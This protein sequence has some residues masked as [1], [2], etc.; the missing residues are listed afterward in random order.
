MQILSALKNTSYA[1][2]PI[3]QKGLSYIRHRML[4]GYV[5]SLWDGTEPASS[6]NYGVPCLLEPD[7]DITAL[8]WLLVGEQFGR[9]AVHEMQTLYTRFQL[10][11]G[12]F[13]SYF[14]GLRF[15]K[16]AC[17]VDYNNAPSL[18]VNLK[19]LGFFGHYGIDST[20]LVRG[21]R[22]LMLEP[23][24]AQKAI[25]YHGLPLLAYYAFNA[26]DEGAP[27]GA[28]I[29]AVMLSEFD[30]S[31]TALSALDTV[32]LSA[33]LWARCR[34][35]RYMKRECP[36][37]KEDVALLKARQFEDGSFAPAPIYF[38]GDNHF[39]GAPSETAAIAIQALETIAP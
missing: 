24:Y 27:E 3:V 29:A 39:H 25:Y 37:T 1:R 6:P 5:W 26:Y 12:L 36:T 2:H 7:P 23:D 16:R 28:V 20:A 4:D 22:T 33:Y 14:V 15:G 18:G 34:F 8:G 17:P 10:P 38:A 11:S 19:V 32:Q 9:S 31:G 13:P 30:S 21:I 35:A